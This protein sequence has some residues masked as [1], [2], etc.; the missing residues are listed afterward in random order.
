MQYA[1]EIGLWTCGTFIYTAIRTMIRKNK[2]NKRIGAIPQVSSLKYPLIATTNAA[3]F[4]STFTGI[5]YG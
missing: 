1:I 2:I 3:A 5:G 4:I